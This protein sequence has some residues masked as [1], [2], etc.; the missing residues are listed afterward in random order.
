MG[1]EMGSPGQRAPLTQEGSS[2][3]RGGSD[4]PGSRTR[5]LRGARVIPQRGGEPAGVMQG[6][7]FHTPSTTGPTV[8]QK[9]VWPRAS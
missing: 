3:A 9:Q 7:R 2:S 6:G 5:A 4:H 8:A 1:G